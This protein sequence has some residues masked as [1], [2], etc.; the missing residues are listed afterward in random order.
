MQLATIQSM[1]N[2]LGFDVRATCNRLLTS[3]LDLFWGAVPPDFSL[4]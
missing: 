2:H 1:S 3:N 4:A